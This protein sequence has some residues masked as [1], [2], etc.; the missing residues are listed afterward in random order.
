MKLTFSEMPL[1]SA[2]FVHL[3]CGLLYKGIFEYLLISYARMLMFMGV[4][5]GKAGWGGHT[6]PQIVGP[7]ILSRPTTTNQKK[8]PTSSAKMTSNSERMMKKMK[9]KLI[10]VCHTCTMM[11]GFDF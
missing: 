4:F 9:K 1:K 10:I 7:R 2:E 5:D 8:M 3:I 6:P 11:I